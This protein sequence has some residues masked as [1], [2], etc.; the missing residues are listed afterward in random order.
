MQEYI[1][2]AKGVKTR[3]VEWGD[4]DKPVILCLHGLG[5]T[6][7][8]F[9]ELAEILKDNYHFIA[10][11]LPGH[12]INSTFKATS[13]F[14]IPNIAKWVKIVC[15]LLEID[16]FYLLAH[17]WGAQISM[18]F[19]SEFGS[20]V[21]K[22]LLL[23]G[24][25]HINKQIKEFNKTNNL[26]L[27]SLNEEIEYQR[28]DFDEYIFDQLQDFITTEKNNYKR[29]SNLLEK[30]TE[31]LAII[32]S[33]K[34]CWHATGD[35][36]ENCLIGIHEHSPDKIYPQIKHNDT[37]KKIMLLQ[38]T[39][40][41]IYTYRDILSEKFQNETGST[42]KKLPLGHMMHWE[43]PEMIVTEIRNWFI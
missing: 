34:Y 28:K 18:Y 1:V 43:N 19:L 12:G 37:G 15:D 9:I 21:K 40:P 23:D 24:G 32:K 22:A 10:I 5:G 25:Y 35:T 30:A 13:D 33:G 41:A 31:D 6:A 38:S 11:D 2:E 42:V 39:T 3:V 17:S 26:P 7:L 27:A 8:S 4:K 14:A 16:D 29:W 36:A 20:K